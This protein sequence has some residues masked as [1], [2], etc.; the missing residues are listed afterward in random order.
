ML[1]F[2]KNL[3]HTFVKELKNI[4]IALIAAVIVWFAI[5][6]QI[7]PD[8]VSHV[9]DVPVTAV[10]T[11]F[12]NQ[13]GLKI[14]D[15]YEDKISV[16]ISGKR[17]DI[18][19]ISGSDFA[20][21]LDLSE[22]T[23]AGEY[24]VGVNVVPVNNVNCQIDASSASVR[25]KVEKI[26]SRKF[27]AADGS[28]NITADSIIP[29][30]N[31]KIDSIVSDPAEVTLTGSEEDI[32]AVKTVEVRADYRG[33]ADSSISSKGKLVLLGANGETI[34]NTAIT[35]DASDFTV[36]V[37]MYNQKTLPLTVRFTNVPNNFDIDSLKY[38]IY[39]EELTIS[40]PDDSIE[41]QESFEVGTIDLSELTPRYLQQ[42][43]LPITLPEGY[44]NSS[45]NTSA[46]VKFEADDYTFLTYTVPKENIVVAN[47]PDNFDV[48]VLTNEIIVSVTGP[49][50][51]IAALTAKN[52]LVTVDLMGTNLSL[53]PIDMNAE[54]IV[55]RSNTKCWVTGEYS[56]SLQVNE[57]SDED[58]SQ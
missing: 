7:F 29:D 5:S 42:I 47:A 20:A 13:N 49:S 56:V 8:I 25:I 44:K 43:T 32:N 10:P 46:I 41:S 3:L 21:S 50:S 18:G 57:K 16:Q 33:K 6:I 17:Y 58:T 30:G 53:G 24:T 12:M 19:N 40:S 55:R 14:A 4:I 54:V 28:M 11:D 34:E 48:E 36:T 45:G 22:I 31:L 27:S 23:S 35:A 15:G 51:D 9:N 38:S 37:T 39:P 52:I 1:S 2:F 26:I